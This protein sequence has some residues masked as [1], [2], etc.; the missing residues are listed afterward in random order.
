MASLKHFLP[1]VGLLIAGGAQA[2]EMYCCQDPHSGR[3]V[4]G[5]SLP[6]QCRG[7][8]Y[9]VLDGA[10]NVIREKEGALTPEQKAQRAAEEKQRREEEAL[11]REQ[12]RKDQA[13][14]DTYG[15]LQDLDIARDRSLGLTQEAIQQAEDKIAELL[16]K[17]KKW[18]DEAEFY[19]KGNLPAEVDRNLRE[20][21]YE[22][23]AYRALVENKQKELEQIRRKYDEDRKRFLEIKAGVRR[24][25]APQ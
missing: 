25:V 2:I 22:L 24:P 18:A 1:V 17:R 16:V 5:D 11:M 20:S 8:P 3:R 23:R 4:C 10:G 9:K 15:S 14:L 21:D 7:K 6:E 13:L 12:R 19:K